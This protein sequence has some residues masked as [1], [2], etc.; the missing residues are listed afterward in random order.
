[1]QRVTAKMPFIS[2]TRG[3]KSNGRAEIHELNVDVWGGEQTSKKMK[4]SSKDLIRGWPGW[5]QVDLVSLQVS[6]HDGSLQKKGEFDRSYR[7]AATKTL[8]TKNPQEKKK[9]LQFGC[10]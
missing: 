1:L 2:I 3:K 6:S 10:A 7:C 4:L 9:E 8:T 5:R